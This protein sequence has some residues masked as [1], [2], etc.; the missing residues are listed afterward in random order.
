MST[1]KR[2]EHRIIA[3]DGHPLT[4]YEKAFPASRATLLLIHGRTW[5]SIPNFDLP[6]PGASVMDRFVAEGFRVLALDQRGY[7]KTRRDDSQLHT[8]QRAVAD[9]VT[10]LRWTGDRAAVL[11]YSWGSLV[12][13]LAAQQHPDLLSAVVLFGHPAP[14]DFAWATM[15]NLPPERKPTTSQAAA[16]DFVVPTHRPEVIDAYARIAPATDPIRMDWSELAQFEALNPI[17][18][19]VPT[20]LIYGDHDPYA[21]QSQLQAHERQLG[22]E[23]KQ[24]IILETADHAAHLGSIGPFT[25][26][27][28]AFIRRFT[29]QPPP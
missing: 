29:E 11:G 20:L 13:H 16:E 4:V 24:R 14:A 2:T 1:A 28:S 3:D 21:Q 19:R 18:L 10:V 17:E 22:A 23:F 27:V 12:A 6:V 25:T 26:A 9:V 15:P 5:S 7:G 8:P